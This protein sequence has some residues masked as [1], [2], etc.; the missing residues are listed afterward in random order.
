[1]RIWV[2]THDYICHMCIQHTYC[3]MSLESS[4]SS[5]VC[6]EHLKSTSEV[7]RLSALL[8]VQGGSGVFASMQYLGIFWF[9]TCSHGLVSCLT[10]V[11]TGNQGTPQGLGREIQITGPAAFW[12]CLCPKQV[13]RWLVGKAGKVH[14]CW[15]DLKEY[16]L[17]A[18]VSDEKAAELQEAHLDHLGFHIGF[19][20]AADWDFLPVLCFASPCRIACSGPCR[21]WDVCKESSKTMAEVSRLSALLE[22]PGLAIQPLSH[23]SRL[24]RLERIWLIESR[25][26]WDLD[27][28]VR[29]LMSFVGST[30]LWW[31][32]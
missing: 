5:G 7:S 4:C 13:S 16:I 32:S 1:M 14:C 2:I 3:V 31:R 11:F 25:S 21:M 29:K 28:L 20:I 27:R 10:H 24:R 15:I 17:K 30:W 18:K 26:F 19:H 12:A 23:P 22:A 6:Q 9:G 8:E